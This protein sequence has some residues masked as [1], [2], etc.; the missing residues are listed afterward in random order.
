VVVPWDFRIPKIRLKTKQIS[1][2]ANSRILVRIDKWDITSLYPEGHYVKSL[3][4]IGHLDTEVQV[5]ME[6]NGINYLPFS[7]NM[8]AELPQHTYDGLLSMGLWF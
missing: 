6:E 3:G 8:L 5:L 1:L 2:I 7:G 4:E